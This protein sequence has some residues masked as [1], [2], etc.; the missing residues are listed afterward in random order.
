MASV[1]ADLLAK[2]ASVVGANHVVTDE[3]LARGYCVDWSG[4]FVG[5]T[6]AVIRPGS[7]DEVAAVLS[8][9]SAALVPVVPQGGNT[10]LVGGGVPLA[11]EVV[12]S[13]QRLNT[14]EAVDT[15]SNQ[16]TCGAGATLSALQGAAAAHG[17]TFGVDLAARDSAT[18]GGMVATNAGGIHVVRYGPMRSQVCGI[19]CVLSNGTVLSHLAGLAKDNTG[20]DLDGLICGSEGTLGIVTKVRVKLYP[21]LTHR[22]T[23]MIALSSIGEAVELVS[24][25]RRRVRELLA[26]EA[27]PSSAMRVVTEVQGIEAPVKCAGSQ[28][29]VW[30]L[31]EAGSSRSD[32]TDEL[33]S[34]LSAFDDDLDV[35][36]ATDTV[37]SQRLWRFREEITDSI[38]QLGVPHKFDVTLAQASLHNFERDVHARVAAVTPNARVVVF[39]HLGDGNLHV[40]VLGLADGAS[41]EEAVLGLVAEHGGSISAEHGIGTAKVDWLHLSRSEAE[42]A[43]FLAIRRALDPH[44]ILNPNVL[45]PWSSIATPSPT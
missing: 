18:V 23:A 24:H 20:Y 21:A 41:A 37:A 19:E 1:N 3:D 5:S 28:D 9:C 42:I 35:A 36:V 27:I 25:L 12:I 2:L 39:G 40:N 11:G 13:L 44:G 43:S 8:L 10:G 45:V 15:L 33:A 14:V 38:N 22:T 31:I 17:L 32:P 6:P 4:R 34:A 30:L 29:G 7:T 16:V 26:I